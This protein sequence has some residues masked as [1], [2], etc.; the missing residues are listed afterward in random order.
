MWCCA[1]MFDTPPVPVLLDDGAGK[2][3][4]CLTWLFCT[5]AFTGTGCSITW[6]F[7][8]IFINIYKEIPSGFRLLP[9]F[10]AFLFFSRAPDLCMLNQLAHWPLMEWCR[11]FSSPKTK[12]FWHRGDRGLLAVFSRAM[13]A[14]N[15]GVINW[16]QIKHF[17]S[18]NQHI[19]KYTYNN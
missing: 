5:A 15:L 3:W 10:F 6:V 9:L 18:L 8:E 14:N 19:L 11:L 7:S 1:N 2:S 16:M 17:S 4:P 13:K 12:P